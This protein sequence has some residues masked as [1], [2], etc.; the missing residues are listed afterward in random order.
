MSAMKLYMNCR[1]INGFLTSHKSQQVYSVLWSLLLQSH[2]QKYYQVLKL[3]IENCAV[4]NHLSWAQWMFTRAVNSL[5]TRT[6][7]MTFT[8]LP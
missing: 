6:A 1:E 5:L 7:T 4:E 8:S 3:F 2:R